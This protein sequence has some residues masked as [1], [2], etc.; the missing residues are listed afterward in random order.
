MTL[1][2]TNEHQIYAQVT[3]KWHQLYMGIAMVYDATDS[4]FNRVHCRLVW[5]RSALSGWAFVD[6]GGLTGR[7][8]IPLGAMGPAGSPQNE[9]DRYP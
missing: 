3:W 2:G 7:D 5:S 4:V 6:A 1:R 9:F 8:L